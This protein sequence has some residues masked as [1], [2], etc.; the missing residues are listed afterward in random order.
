MGSEQRKSYFWGVFDDMVAS[1]VSL[2]GVLRT[3]K[4]AHDG[5]F[6]SRCGAAVVTCI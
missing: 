6:C 1:S 4:E 5:L 3:F 2:G